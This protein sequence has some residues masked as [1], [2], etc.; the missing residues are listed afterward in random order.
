MTEEQQ[1][2][3]PEHSADGR[4]DGEAEIAQLRDHIRRLESLAVRLSD[5]IRDNEAR[6]TRRIARLEAENAALRDSLSAIG[7][8]TSWRLTAP[9]RWLRQQ[10]G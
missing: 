5:A 10:I 9:L 2:S 7:A 8:S 6:H 3:P 4:A 1:V